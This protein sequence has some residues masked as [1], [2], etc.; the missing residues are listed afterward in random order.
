VKVELENPST[1]DTEVCDLGDGTVVMRFLGCNNHAVVNNR[2]VIEI[3]KPVPAPV[4]RPRTV[5]AS[6]TPSVCVK[7]VELNIWEPSAVQV[8]GVAEVIGHRERQDGEVGDTYQTDVSARFGAVFMEMYEAGKLRYSPMQHTVLAVIQRGE[9]EFVVYEG[10]ASGKMSFSAEG[11]Q[12]GDT[13]AVFFSTNQKMTA[14]PSYRGLFAD[15]L[16]F[17]VNA[18]HAI[19]GDGPLLSSQ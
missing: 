16:P 1:R 5:I 9:Q 11:Y 7:S 3:A 13:F 12:K 6:Q 2:M 4:L 10:P 17:C 15:D 8:P 18:M 19:E 14:F